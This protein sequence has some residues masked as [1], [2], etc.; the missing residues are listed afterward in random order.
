MC[1]AVQVFGSA[2]GVRVAVRV[3]FRDS[4]SALFGSEANAYV[5]CSLSSSLLFHVTSCIFARKNWALD[6]ANKARAQSKVH[7]ATLCSR[8]FVSFLC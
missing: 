6:L 7:S 5:C 1:D 3:V 2:P 8:L 4:V